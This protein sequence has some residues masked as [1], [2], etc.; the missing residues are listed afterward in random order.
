MSFSPAASARHRLLS[1]FVKYGSHGHSHSVFSFYALW[2][3]GTMVHMLI[4]NYIRRRR[5]HVI[6]RTLSTTYVTSNKCTLHIHNNNNVRLSD[7]QTKIEQDKA[8]LTRQKNE[9]QLKLNFNRTPDNSITSHLFATNGLPSSAAGC[10]YLGMN[11][12]C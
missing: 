7:C 10:D 11:P 2:Y 1:C 3:Y 9:R 4:N 12:Q 5:Y 6:F 8:K